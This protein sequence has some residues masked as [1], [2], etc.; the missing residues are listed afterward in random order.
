MILLEKHGAKKH[1]SEVLFKSAVEEQNKLRSEQSA[2]KSA[3]K[4][5]IG[6]A[7]AAS[8]AIGQ[9]M[10]AMRE[11][12]EKLETLDN[13]TSQLSGDASNYAQMA[14][15]MKEKNKKKATFWGVSRDPV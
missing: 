1:S 2:P 9:V 11:R 5:T 4:K 3:A 14:K 7:K 12:G 15:Q 13:K 10:S 6:K 8:G